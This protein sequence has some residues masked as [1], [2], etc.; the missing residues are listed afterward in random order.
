MDALFYSYT[1]T[2]ADWDP[3]KTI[4]LCPPSSHCKTWEDAQSY[5]IRSG[6]QAVAEANKCLLIVPLAEEGWEAL[7]EDHLMSLYN[8]FKNDVPARQGRSIWGRGGKVWCWEIILFAVGYGDG[9]EYVSRVQIACPG[10][11]AA[12]ALV[13][14]CTADFSSSEKP[15]SHWLVPGASE[16]YRKRNCEIPVQTWL[17]TEDTDGCGKL[18]EYWNGVNQ[19]DTFGEEIVGGLLSDVAYSG[20]HPAHQVR[21]FSGT[22]SAEPKLAEHIFFHCFS[23]V[24]RWKNG[25]DGTLALVPSR[26]EFY[27]NPANL[28]RTIG[29]EGN[30]Y[31][32]FLHLPAGKQTE[33]VRGLPLVVS[34][35]GRGEPAWMYSN[36]NGWESLSDETG[37]FV[38]LTPD[39][40][41]NIWF[42]SRD[43]RAFPLMIAQALEE[44]GLDPERVYLTGFSNGGTMTRELSLMYPDLF[45]AISPWNG[46]G[47]DTAAM[48]E[49]D[50]SRIPSCVL[51]QLRALADRLLQEG[52]EMP[53]FMFY[54]DRDMGIGPDSN[55]LLPVYLQA[56]GCAAL[57][58]PQCPAGYR[59]DWE[60]TAEKEYAPLS[61]GHRFHTYAYRGVHGEPAVCVTLMKNMPHGAVREQ[62]RVTWEFFRH[63]RRPVQSKSVIFKNTDRLCSEKE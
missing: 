63:Y 39:S 42:R 51:P 10:F 43:A 21:V 47:M 55:L 11:L 54:G 37:A 40:P 46:P 30:Y 23:H 22:F 59:P 19:A 48:L 13:N 57:P 1:S 53:A 27:K 52:W 49:Q 41:G 8:R 50:T 9:A 12:C 35:H 6:W 60:Y 33:E 62:S 32:Y 18:A 31:D 16:D 25:P 36:K 34:I 45:A 28:R 61:E 44:F 17:Y 7:P 2:L 14:G 29:I 5:A 58:E 15:S 20:K 56:N 38:T 3:A 26:E 4:F 24:V